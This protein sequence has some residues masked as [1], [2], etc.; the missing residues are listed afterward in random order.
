MAA[1][2]NSTDNRR[3]PYQPAVTPA[4]RRLLGVLLLL[5]ALIGANS[6]Y[7]VTVTCIEELTSQSYQNFFYQYMFLAHLVLGLV[8]IAPFLI[9]SF[10]HMRNTWRRK[11]RR[12]VRMGY[13]LF[14]ASLILLATGLLLTRAGPLEIRSP[15][16]RQFFYWLHVLSPLVILWFYWLHRLAGPS[17]KWK[18]GIGYLAAA[19]ATCLVMIAMHSSDPRAWYQ[20]GSK[21]GE[22]YFEPSLARTDTGKFIPQEVLM[23]DQYCKECHADSHAD[24]A[25]SAHRFSS[26]NN[27]AYLVSVRETREVSLRKDGDPKRVRW[28]AGCHDPVPFFSGQ[29]D[30]PQFSDVDNPTAHAGI[31]CTVC[32]AI[33]NVNSSRGNA[34]YTIEEPLHYPFAFSKNPALKW[35]NK[36]LVKAKPSFH[37]KT[38]LKPFHQEADFCSVCHKVH[39]PETVNDYKFLRG[40]NH[41]DSFL[42]SG[43]SG[44][45]ARSFYYPKRAEQNCNGCHMPLKPSDDFGA[46]PFDTTT[47]PSIHNHLFLGANTALPYWHGHTQ[48]LKAHQDFLKDCVRV[49]IFGLREGGTIEGKLV[50]PLRPDRPQ[51]EPGKRYLLEVVIRTLSLGHHFTQGTADSNE[52][53]LEIIAR[54]DGKIVGRSGQLD[55]QS[56]VDPW[57]HFVNVFMLDREGYRINRRNAQDIFIPLYNHQIPPGAGQTVH[58]GL[59]VPAD[60]TAPLEIEVKLQYRKFNQ[61]YMRLVA[62]NL[63]LEDPSIGQEATPDQ[64]HNDLPITTLAEDRILLPVVGGAASADQIQAFESPNKIPV[65]QRWNDYGIGSLLKGKAELRQASEAFEQV[66]ELNRYDGPLNLARVLFREG[67]LDE[68]TAAIRQAAQHTNPPP[69]AWTL[70]WLSGLVNRQ[71]GRLDEAEENF[72]SILEERTQ[73]QIDRGFDFSQDYEII[74]LLGQTLFEKSRAMRGE[75]RRAEKDQLIDESITWFQRTLAIDPE[76]VTAHYNLQLLYAAKGDA[77]QQTH[78]QQMHLKYKP[79]DNARDRAVAAARQRYPAANHAANAVVVYDLS[80]SI[81]PSPPTASTDALR[82]PEREPVLEASTP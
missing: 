10:F 6:L 65:W 45:G 28:C 17:I 41:H 80:R 16:T 58:Y 25:Q 61:E 59:D 49:D 47:V 22:T 64:Y 37:K 32:H 43:V 27:P 19:G 66:A 39:L 82:L 79:D 70:A 38:F 46:K 11:N 51:L 72:R 34:D 18:L 3:S 53:W 26:F 42:L 76:N 14:F 69:P 29:L 7:L 4:L 40:Q 57:S 21:T 33:T 56:E 74:N 67:R 44:H 30:D 75:S 78:H 60:N 1:S 5:V 63:S 77:S 31:T 48:V 62:K 13:A 36:Q 71:Q 15:T 54:Q 20:V 35:I 81:S 73:E 12:A 52:I 9:F 50:A 24:W 2:R 8:L 68:A 23:N 55:Q